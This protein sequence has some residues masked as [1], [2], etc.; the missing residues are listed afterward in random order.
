LR[1]I[2]WSSW[3]HVAG[4]YDGRLRGCTEV[5]HRL[6]GSKGALGSFVDWGRWLI[7]AASGVDWRYRRVVTLRLLVPLH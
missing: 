1:D 2:Y 6:V 5:L 3:S 7:V 4:I